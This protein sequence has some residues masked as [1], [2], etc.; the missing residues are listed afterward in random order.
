MC[1]FHQDV[2]ND[3]ASDLNDNGI[4]L[5]SANFPDNLSYQDVVKFFRGRLVGVLVANIPPKGVPKRRVSTLSYVAI[6]RGTELFQLVD[7]KSV[8]HSPVDTK[9][10]RAMVPYNKGP[11]VQWIK[12]ISKLP[13]RLHLSPNRSNIS[14][15]VP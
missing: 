3:R 5:Q 1:L 6:H 8:F 4:C 2:S 12:D 13:N 7:P 9:P 15:F 10:V 11:T 14:Y